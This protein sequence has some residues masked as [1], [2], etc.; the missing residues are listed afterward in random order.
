[1]AQCRLGWQTV[2]EERGETVSN[3]RCA[4]HIRVIAV[5]TSELNED[6][7]SLVKLGEQCA[8]NLRKYCEGESTFG[9][10]ISTLTTAPL[11]TS[12]F[13]WR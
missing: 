4:F 8:P 12:P 6:F 5:Y 10:V 11:S 3:S 1:M 9:N 13:W 2:A 7:E